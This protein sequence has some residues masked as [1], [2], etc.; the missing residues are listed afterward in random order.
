MATVIP[1]RARRYNINQVE[2]DRVVAP[3]YDVIS[4]AEQ[5]ALYA[6]DA[7]NIIK[8]ELGIDAPN[9]NETNNKYERARQYLEEWTDQSILAQDK[10]PGFY[11]HETKFPDPETGAKRRR[12][13]LFGLIK[14]EPFE[15][16]TVLPHEK[17]HSGPKE[18]RFKLLTAT[19]T[20]FSPV[21]GLYDDP[22]KII[23][24]LHGRFQLDRPLFSFELENGESHKLWQITNSLEVAR[25]S[26]M[27]EA[28]SI[29]IADGHH[30]Y[31]T[32]LRYAEEQRKLNGGEAALPSDYALMGLVE[33]KDEGLLI[34]PIHRMIKNLPAIGDCPDVPDLP[35]FLGRLS[36]VFTVE[37]VGPE[38]LPKIAKG[39]LKSGFGI[40][41]GEE[42]YYLKLKNEDTARAEMPE[43]KPES[44]Y[45]LEVAQ[46][47]HLVLKRLGIP[48]GAFEGHVTYTKSAEEA[49]QAAQSKEAS[50]SL[51]VPPIKAETMQEICKSGELMP[52]KSTYFHPKLGSGFLMYRHE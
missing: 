26:R 43:G 30:R 24:R 19:K 40:Q 9:D 8:L 11:L 39:K 37:K 16:R 17:T 46:I 2:I 31:E 25:I 20:N 36:E 10:L 48:E 7:H 6:R 13:V 38:I 1:F 42:S 18:D 49:I 51:I 44:W 14:L 22:E 21:F 41:L 32:A 28:K 47:S 4:Q 15:K 33:S 45:R 50:L 29:L 34:F 5:E 35:P 12:I 52:Q 27:F 3:P 23:N